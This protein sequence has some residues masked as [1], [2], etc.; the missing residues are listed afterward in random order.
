ML[1]ITPET[2]LKIASEILMHSRDGL[3]RAS[4]DYAEGNCDSS[5]LRAV[6]ACVSGTIEAVERLQF[7]YTQTT[8]RSGFQ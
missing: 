1:N 7:Q 4:R 8:E 2:K 3:Q 5:H 6:I